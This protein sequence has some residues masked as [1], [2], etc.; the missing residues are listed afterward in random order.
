MQNRPQ[1]ATPVSASNRPD[2]RIRPKSSR[3][4]ERRSSGTTIIRFSL[5]EN[6]HGDGPV[7]AKKWTKTVDGVR[8]WDLEN[9]EDDNNSTKP[10]SRPTTPA[11]PAFKQSRS[12]S[13]SWAGVGRPQTAKVVQKMTNTQTK[14]PSTAPNKVARPSTARPSGPSK[15]SMERN[16]SETVT[17]IPK[18]LKTAMR[19][20]SK[21]SGA[22]KRPS[23]ASVT[24]STASDLT[25]NLPSNLTSTES[26]QTEDEVLPP[27]SGRKIVKHNVRNKKD[28]K[29]ALRLVFRTIFF[30]RLFTASRGIW[31]NKLFFDFIRNVF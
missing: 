18:R 7:L 27:S 4:I 16:V 24:F 31:A 2:H 11:I 15:I 30:G 20:G 5:S 23:T 3:N 6:C 29:E 8:S 14:R 13:S 19:R 25:M 10:K 1:T 17:Q 28:A 22:H 26:I 21:S 9:F 12:R